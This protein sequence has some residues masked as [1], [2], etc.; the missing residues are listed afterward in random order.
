MHTEHSSVAARYAEAIM[1]LAQD[2]PGMATETILTNL[3]QVNKTIAETENLPQVLGHPSVS[4][5][6]KKRMLN[7]LFADKINEL[8]LR[9]LE[10]MADKR[11]LSLL[12]QLEEEYRQLLRVR[13][14]IV[15]ASLVAASQPG[16][17][18]VES[19]KH[20]LSTK[21]GKRVEIDVT[22]DKSLIGGAILRLGD[23]VIDGSLK[24]K[25]ASIEKIFVS[26]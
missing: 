16:D 13:Q 11:R 4:T 8:A 14:N 1:D 19:I 15:S 20:K 25:L 10:L 21:L 2:L 5:S 9:L 6:D 3:V 24:G 12:P 7:E 23:Q 18:L 26:V 17:P 22:V